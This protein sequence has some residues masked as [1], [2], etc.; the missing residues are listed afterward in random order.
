[1]V[2]VISYY[3]IMLLCNYVISNDK[4]SEELS[5]LLSDN[6]SDKF[7]TLKFMRC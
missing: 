2:N 5:E 3:V 4:L 7:T 6:L 1:M